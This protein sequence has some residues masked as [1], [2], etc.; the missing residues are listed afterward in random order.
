MAK[1]PTDN[2]ENNLQHIKA[3]IKKYAESK[4][5][6]VALNIAEK[7]STKIADSAGKIGAAVCLGVA[8]LFLLVALALFA[9]HKLDNNVLGFVV[10]SGPCLIGG[11]FLYI[12]APPNIAKKLQDTFAEKIDDVFENEDDSVTNNN[13]DRR[14]QLRKEQLDGNK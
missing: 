9:G 8:F 4:V 10:A 2:I 1:V 3:D 13:G 11:L 12:I 14:N 7:A 6:L 5:K